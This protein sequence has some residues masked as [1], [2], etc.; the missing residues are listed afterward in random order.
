MQNFFN[1]FP[2]NF[3]IL[4]AVGFSIAMILG[5]VNIDNF[6]PF[7]PPEEN[8]VV[9]VKFI[10]QGEGKKPIEG[11][12]V[13]FIFDGAPETKFTNTDGYVRIEIPSRKDIDVVLSKEGFKTID[14]TINLQGERERTRILILKK[15]SLSSNPPTPPTVPD[16]PIVLQ[17]QSNIVSTRGFDFEF[18]GCEAISTDEIICSFIVVNNQQTRPLTLWSDR[19]KI[20]DGEGNTIL[21][22]EGQLGSRNPLRTSLDSEELPPKIPIK[23]QVL[24]REIPAEPGATFKIRYFE[25]NFNQ[26]K[27]G[28]SAASQK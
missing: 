6:P 4:L 24:F 11:V 27:I 12:E 20:I 7:Y 18:I 17:Q 23:G 14:R 2:K 22:V 21:G 1:N 8:P 25:L 9:E 10:V 15:S 16:S 5:I 26:F 3:K 28:F 13:Q 19:S